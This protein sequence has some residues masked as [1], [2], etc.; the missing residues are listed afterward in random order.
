MAGEQCSPG[1]IWDT[2]VKSCIPQDVLWQ[3]Q[4]PFAE[5]AMVMSTGPPV[6]CWWNVAVWIIVCA[7]VVL[8]SSALILWVIVYRQH[9]HGKRNSKCSASHHRSNKTN[10]YDKDGDV[11]SHVNSKQEVFDCEMGWGRGSCKARGEPVVPLPATE[12]G[13][14]ALVTTKTV[15]LVNYSHCDAPLKTNRK[16][17][18]KCAIDSGSMD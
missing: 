9:T 15:Q 14:S 5:A 17:T 16:M 12:L 2:L 13:D 4:K 10:S 7:V 8:S 6:Q 3:T 18:G 11:G 1:F